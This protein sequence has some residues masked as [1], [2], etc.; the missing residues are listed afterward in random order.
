MEG[1][2]REVAKVT[3]RASHKPYNTFPKVTF[4]RGNRS[5]AEFIEERGFISAL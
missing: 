1:K 4:G 2:R 5:L 3:N